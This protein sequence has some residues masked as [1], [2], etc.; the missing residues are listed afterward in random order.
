MS[1]QHKETKIS[2]MLNLERLLLTLL[3][4]FFLV[5]SFGQ[6]NLAADANLGVYLTNK[7]YVIKMEVS[8]S[9]NRFKSKEAASSSSNYLGFSTWRAALQPGG[10]FFDCISNSPYKHQIAFGE[11][12]NLFWQTS[13][14]GI[15][16]APKSPDEGGSDKN[17]RQIISLSF[18]KAIS[19]ILNFGIEGLDTQHIRWL[20][21]TN[22]TASLVDWVGNSTE[23][24]VNVSF[25]L[26]ADGLPARFNCIEKSPNGLRYYSID[27]IYD[28]LIFPPSRTVIQQLSN[29]GIVISSTTNIIH[30][31]DFGLIG[32]PS[33]GFFP[34]DITPSNF[35]PGVNIVQ[36]NGSRFLISTNGSL[37]LISESNDGTAVPRGKSHS[38]RWFLVLLLCLPIIIFILAYKRRLGR[39]TI[40][41]PLKPK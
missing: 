38:L 2:W 24:N 27:C 4:L 37:I 16:K 40:N 6:V 35:V 25:I 10:F 19:D 28:H 30:Y 39:K 7:P 17:G 13:P 41:E 34:S 21:D 8:L 23:G 3:A 5:E 31:I 9:N 14:K 18:K 33:R 32:M 36:S 29:R 26:Q 15:S 20:S 12:S 1:T 11:S 22:F